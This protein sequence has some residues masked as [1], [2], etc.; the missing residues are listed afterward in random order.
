MKNALRV[1]LALV[2]A[3]LLSGCAAFRVLNPFDSVSASD[4]EW[5]AV[6][7]G[8]V[9]S[10]TATIAGAVDERA[11]LIASILSVLGNSDPLGVL[12]PVSMVGDPTPRYILCSENFYQKCKQIPLNSKIH[13]AGKPVG[14]GLLWKP[15]RLT[16]EGF[17]D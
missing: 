8:E 6:K 15:T 12:M 13:F 5:D 11:S 7:S 4:A 2:L 14:P 3:V 17:N 9:I 1:S 16:A 10:L